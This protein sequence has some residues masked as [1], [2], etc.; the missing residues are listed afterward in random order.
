MVVETRRL[1]AKRNDEELCHK[2]MSDC[3]V[4]PKVFN[5][6]YT[7]L[8]PQGKRLY[9]CVLFIPGADTERT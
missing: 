3:D 1:T 2:I 9:V 8:K 6:M 4:I 5:E 7:V